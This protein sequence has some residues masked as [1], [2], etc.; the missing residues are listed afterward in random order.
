MATP[1]MRD[2]MVLEGDGWRYEG[3]VRTGTVTEEAHGHGTFTWK[4]DPSDT[5]EGEWKDDNM[6][7]KGVYT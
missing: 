3:Q 4:K 5:Y 6:S 1:G 7:G 2:R